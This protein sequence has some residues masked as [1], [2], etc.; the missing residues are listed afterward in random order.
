MEET[1]I[2]NKTYAPNSLEW[3]SASKGTKHKI[4]WENEAEGK[5]KIAE[6]FE[7]EKEMKLIFKSE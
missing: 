1:T 2:I 7:I 6:A 3:G 5:L 4:Y